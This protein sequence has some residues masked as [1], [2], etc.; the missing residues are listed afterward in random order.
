MNR[1]AAFV[2]V[3][4]LA[5]CAGQGDASIEPTPTHHPSA[6]PSGLDVASGGPSLVADTTLVGV[7]SA[8]T[9]EGGC[10]FLEAEDGDRYELIW[11]EGWSV[12]DQLEI[13][14]AA[15]DVVAEGGARITVYGREAADMGS[16]CQVGQIIEVTEVTVTE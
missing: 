3:L 2:L 8:D 11:P 4:G 7:L 6:V 12:G 15:G 16:I 10:I 14:D 5:A 9:I 1:L 13:I